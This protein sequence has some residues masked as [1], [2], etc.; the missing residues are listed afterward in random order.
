MFCEY[1]SNF[2]CVS[3]ISS[4]VGKNTITN[5]MCAIFVCLV[6][7]IR[8][9]VTIFVYVFNKGLKSFSPT[10]KSPLIWID[11]ITGYISFYYV[12]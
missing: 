8:V 11:R 4:R 10:T 1:F 3:G 6:I 5:I 2:D 7:N 9:A 12:S